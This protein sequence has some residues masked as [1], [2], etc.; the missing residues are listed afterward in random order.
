MP[1]DGPL[2][3]MFYKERIIPFFTILIILIRETKVNHI[4]YSFEIVRKVETE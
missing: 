2:A 1:G 4:S 3:Y